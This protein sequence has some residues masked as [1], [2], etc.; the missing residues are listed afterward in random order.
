MVE[1]TETFK[2]KLYKSNAFQHVLGFMDMQHLLEFRTV[3]Q[4][5]ADEIVP[6]CI[7]YLKYECPEEDDDNEYTFQKKIRHAKKLEIKNI[8]GTEAHLKLAR[9]VITHFPE[10]LIQIYNH[11]V[12]DVVLI[13]L[14]VE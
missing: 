7:P 14:S 3:S 5:M 8:C 4:K 11:A 13:H 10:T 1:S 6:R 9:Y 2:R 12:S